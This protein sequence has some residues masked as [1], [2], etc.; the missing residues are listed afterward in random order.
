MTFQPTRIVIVG[1][2]FGGTYLAQALERKLRGPAVEILLID[3]HNYFI[4]YPLMVEAG[5][6]SLEPRH[7]VVSI[8]SFLKRTRFRMGRVAAVDQDRREVV[9]QP[10]GVERRERIGYDHLVLALGSVTRL[11][12]LPGL[13]EHAFEMKQLSDAVA[14]RDRAI[15]LLE[16][17]DASDD[18]EEQRRLLHFVVVGSNF[19][20]T[21]V[22]GEFD[23]FLKAASRQYNHIDPRQCRVTLV[24]IADRILPALDRDLSRYAREQL[25]NRGVD[26]RLNTSA[27]R[28]EHDGVMLDSGERLAAQTVVWCAGIAPNPLLDSMNLPRDERG[29]VYCEPDMRVEGSDHIWAI[30]DNA[31]NPD[32]DGTP[33]PPTAQ[34]A[35]A[36]ARDLAANLA[37]VLSN[38]P[39]RPAAI[40]T[41]GTLAALGCR[42]AVARV[43]G[44][45]LSGFPAWFLWRTVYLFKMPGW[46]RRLR[47]ALDWTLGLFFGRDYVQLGI[48]RVDGSGV[49]E[50][51]GT[52]RSKGRQQK[53]EQRTAMETEALSR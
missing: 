30:G 46:A 26:I 39:T 27:T 18:P 24:E 48:H 37:R 14:L 43:F 44:V 16:L 21:E 3:Q 47:I 51:T 28:I 9:V 31:I 50:T 35:I 5:T 19:T 32:P 52:P 6:G 12:D 1:G 17:A 53:T 49:V 22:A 2:G 13:R 11:P 38:R 41:K 45:K 7:T 10:P 33:Y 4:F 20:G 34:H 36:Q 8:R 42:T 15:Q 25:Q 29:F 40:A 23:A